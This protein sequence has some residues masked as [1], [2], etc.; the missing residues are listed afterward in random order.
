MNYYLSSYLLGNRTDYL[1]QMS[2]KYPKIGY[3]SNATDFVGVDADRLKQTNESNINSLNEL[4]FEVQ[5]LDLQ[6]YFGSPE[7]LKTKLGELQY[8]IDNKILFKALKDGEVLIL[9]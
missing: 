5:N 7:K 1:K 4:G 8:Y 6:D 2:P 9:E 3:I